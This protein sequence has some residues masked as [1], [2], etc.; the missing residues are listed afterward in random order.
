MQ[1]QM[2]TAN[3]SAFWRAAFI[4][5][6]LT[7]T[8]IG[9]VMIYSA[10]CVRAADGGTDLSF[11]SKQVVWLLLGGAGMLIG[12][13]VNWQRHKLFIIAA[14]T[15][16]LLLLVAVLVPG[17]GTRVNGA[18]RWLRFGGFN[19]Q[20]SELLKITGVLMLAFF[21]TRTEEKYLPFVSIFLPAAMLAGIPVVI[22]MIE[23]DVGTAALIGVVLVSM[24]L[25]AGARIWQIILT[26]I[27]ALP[28]AVVIGL[29]KMDYIM[30]RVA[31]WQ[32]GERDGKGYQTWMS[33]V[34]LGS[35]GLTGVGLG[36]GPAKLYYLPE[37]HTDFVLAIIG[38]ELGLCGTLFVIALFLTFIYAGL[39][40][41]RSAPNRFSLLVIYGITAMIG[42]QAAFNI[43]VV[44]ASIPPKGISLPFISFGGSGLCIA[45]TA[46]GM[47][48]GITKNSEVAEV[49]AMLENSETENYTDDGAQKIIPLYHAIIDDER[50]SA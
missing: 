1:M 3:Y 42:L 37:A 18:Y 6:A 50:K 33:Q 10:S 45:L 44:T 31:A 5:S 11:L 21:L 12:S 40:L 20:P 17:V 41:M 4:G 8:T 16:S 46:I 14:F 30:Q 7:L 47:V 29:T 19:M 35:G 38:Q 26:M 48:M 25:V 32:A 43:A 23:P 49:E 28:P 36:E 15:F 27:L 39:S 13:R 9:V 34:A 22:I 24:L 2:N